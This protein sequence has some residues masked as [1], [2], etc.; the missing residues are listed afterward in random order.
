[1]DHIS[2]PGGSTTGGTTSNKD[3]YQIS[4]ENIPADSADYASSCF[5]GKGMQNKTR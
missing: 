5:N 4:T 3:C 2:L 1:M